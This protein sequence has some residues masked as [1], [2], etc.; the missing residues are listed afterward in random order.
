MQRLIKKMRLNLLT[1]ISW[2]TNITIGPF[3]LSYEIVCSH[4]KKYIFICLSLCAIL[5]LCASV[6]YYPN[7]VIKQWEKKK[8]ERE[9]ERKKDKENTC[10]CII[11]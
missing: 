7:M 11:G 9:K 1:V 10:I 5:L 2:L 3:L 6:I 4:L 8:R